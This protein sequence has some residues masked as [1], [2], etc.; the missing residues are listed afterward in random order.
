MRLVVIEQSLRAFCPQELHIVLSFATIVPLQETAQVLGLGFA[1]FD[2]AGL[3]VIFDDCSNT[4][5][6]VF[7]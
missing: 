5:N 1:F 2:H 6:V 3:N 4:R 7:P